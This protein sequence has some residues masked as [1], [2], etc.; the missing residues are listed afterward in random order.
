MEKQT[1]NEKDPF[2]ILEA[3]ASQDSSGQE[4]QN[5]VKELLEELG[6]ETYKSASETDEAK[7]EVEEE[8]SEAEEIDIEAEEAKPEAE[9]VK[10]EIEGT[11]IEVEET[12]VK[13]EVEKKESDI[14]KEKTPEEKTAEEKVAEAKAEVLLSSMETKKHSNKH[15]RRV[16][17]VCSIL[18]TII[19][20]ICVGALI[21]LKSR[22]NQPKPR[23]QQVE[24]QKQEPLA[25]SSELKLSGNGLA[26]FDLAFLKKTDGTSNMIY[27][28][29]S[30]KYALA[31][32]SDGAAGDS[33]AQIEGLIG[34][35][36]PT[37]YLNSANRSIANA[38]MVRSDVAEGVKE[39]YTSTIAD[40]YNASLI[41]DT[42]ETPDNANR[43]VGEKTLGIINNLFDESTLNQDNAFMLINALAID[44]YWNN[45]LHC[46]ASYGESRT[47]PCK[48]QSTVYSAYY[49]HE[50]HSTSIYPVFGEF[51]K[52]SF[53]NSGEVDSARIGADVNR[54]DIISELGEEYIRKT[55]LDEYEKWSAL[56]ENH[57]GD[58]EFDI[59]KYMNELGSSYGKIGGSTDFYYYVTD[60]EKVFAKDLQEY[61]GE[62]LQYVGIMPQGDSLKN[63][64]G[65]MTAE[66]ASQLID[67]LKDSADI[68]NYKD[69]IVTSIS[70]HIPFFEYDYM[71]D[72][73][74]NDLR[75]LGV[76]DV[77]DSSKANLSN[78]IEI[79][80]GNNPYIDATMHAANINFSN[81]GIKAAAVTAMGGFG[82]AAGGFDYVWD[83]PVEKIDMTFDQPF[84]YLIRNK[85]TGEVWFTGAVYNI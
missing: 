9:E 20:I 37:P 60:N 72:S 61:D 47:V 46:D 57:G 76:K 11:E 21:Y 7:P 14:Q 44:M 52:V 3:N 67:N 73:L 58:P 29:L 80:N 45:Q 70:G 79:N 42:F 84:M 69:G 66:K 16:L 51:D 43:W 30:I 22:E 63:Y 28:P 62:T 6:V 55:V 32:L 49:P 71:L 12:E 78:M 36:K 75:E 50:S 38:M 8:V 74:M 25:P 35:Y 83:V 56:P 4:K 1:Q 41:V 5:D 53:A 18:L 40:K 10:P 27:S 13:P 2:D 19:C 33:K 77:F 48:N 59:E 23:S 81:D 85:R 26:D 68:N 15:S 54:Y 39:S 64:I 17:I 31:M 34:D 65:N 82:A 24:P